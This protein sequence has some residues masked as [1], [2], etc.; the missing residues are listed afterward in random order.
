M[1]I[2]EEVARQ[3][4]AYGALWD[5]DVVTFVGSIDIKSGRLPTSR[6]LQAMISE[7]LRR[8]PDGDGVE[9]RL[10]GQRLGL[11][12]RRALD[13][14]AGTAGGDESTSFGDGDRASLPGESTQYRALRYAC[15]AD[16]CPREAFRSFHDARF[17]PLCESH[18]LAMEL[19]AWT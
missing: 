13:R 9:V 18:G 17:L 16:A 5:A 10:D 4:A 6:R 11:S 14:L 15:P 12:S 2:S 1:A 19:R 8:W 7:E 3:R